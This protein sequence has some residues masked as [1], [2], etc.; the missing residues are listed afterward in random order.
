MALSLTS[1]LRSE[2]S[3]KVTVHYDGQ[4]MR[5]VLANVGEDHLTLQESSTKQRVIP[6]SA[7]TAVVTTAPG[8][9]PE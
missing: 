5:R 8:R 9:P 7:I 6:F 3:Q 1:R 4:T 2:I